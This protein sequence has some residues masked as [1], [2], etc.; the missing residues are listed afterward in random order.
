MIKNLLIAISL[1]VLA[2]CST[3]SV[4]GTTPITDRVRLSVGIHTGYYHPYYSPYYS[5]YRHY[6]RQP[7][8][9]QRHYRAYQSPRP[10]VIP[11]RQHVQPRVQPRHNMQQPNR[12]NRGQGRQRNQR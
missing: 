3:Y 6:Y 5:P 11:Q 4:S 1:L 8:I 10:R 2:G 7:V 12:G 9:I